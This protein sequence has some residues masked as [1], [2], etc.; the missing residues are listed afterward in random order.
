LREVAAPAVIVAAAFDRKKITPALREYAI[1][2]ALHLDHLAALRHSLAN[3]R[4]LDLSAF[5]LARS[6]GLSETESRT[7]LDRLLT[8]HETEWKSFMHS[9]GPDSFVADWAICAR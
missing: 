9:L 5:Q 6:C 1:A 3:A 8:Q 7:R 4:M 2:G